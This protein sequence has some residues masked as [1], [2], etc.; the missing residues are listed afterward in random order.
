MVTFEPKFA[1]IDANSMPM[2]PLPT[3]TRCFG[4]VFRSSKVLLE[5]TFEFV[6]SNGAYASFE[7]VFMMINS[8]STTF[9]SPFEVVTKTL[10][11][12]LN[13]PTP[14]ITSIFSLSF[15]IA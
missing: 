2:K 1:N 4:I 13:E 6:I 11:L 3:M 7:P 8:P 12:S 5:K 14:S 15:S 10:F 9:C